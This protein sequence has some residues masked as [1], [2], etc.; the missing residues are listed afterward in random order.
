M[1]SKPGSCGDTC[2][3]ERFDEVIRESESAQGEAQAS[4]VSVVSRLELAAQRLER[5]V[6]EMSRRE[7][8]FDALRRQGGA[9]GS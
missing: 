1:P 2:R 6:E 3:D 4:L 9:D 7:A 5:V 8:P